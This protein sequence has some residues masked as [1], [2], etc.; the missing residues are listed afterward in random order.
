[1]G[2]TVP[3]RRTTQPKLPLLEQE[4]IWTAEA[5][6]GYFVS[7][8]FSAVETAIPAGILVVLLSGCGGPKEEGQPLVASEF[9]GLPSVVLIS[10]DTLRADHL[11]VYGYP[12]PTSPFL[13]S[14][15][16]ECVVFENVIAPCPST[17][18]SVASIMT[19]LNRAR[20]GLIKNQAILPEDVVT[21]AEYL[22]AQGYTTI[23]VNAHPLL[24]TGTPG[25]DQ[26][27]DVYFMPD[28]VPRDGPMRFDGS[29]L[30]D[31]VDRVL[32]KRGR[33][34]LFLW[35]HFVEPHG[36]YN[37]PAEYLA[38]FPPDSY[39]SPG[40]SELPVGE[41]NY[42]YGLIPEYQTIGPRKATVEEYIAAYDAEIRYVDDHVRR[43]AEVLER[44]R[45]WQES[46]VVVTADHGES[47]GEHD[48]YFQHGYHLYEGSVR[49]PLLMRAPRLFPPGARVHQ[50][51]S[52]LD[53]FPTVA[54]YVGIDPGIDFDGES[55]LSLCGGDGADRAVFSQTYYGNSLTALRRGELKYIWSPPPPAPESLDR[56]NSG[57]DAWWE[58][59]AS[60][61]FYDLA[62]DPEELANRVDQDAANSSLFRGLVQKWLALQKANARGRSPFFQDDEEL[63]RA[64]KA[65]GYTE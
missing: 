9:E 47:L 22:R 24:V 35:V 54:E 34:P 1:M 11:E 10:I 46:L 19:G 38:L 33:R 57:W 30:P 15:A 42:G 6:I 32:G 58:T 49:V 17:G 39:R 59:E 48:Y 45:L 65:L 8:R 50:T 51:V 61:E 23:G 20:H 60:E 13:E 28:E 52:L 26:G 25:F 7:M 41:T 55:L 21:L 64:M 14:L 53:L 37:P 36:P 43:V 31:A 16:E 62:R 63:D 27:F 2:L 29:S 12:R 4:R 18:P 3:V 56:W 40:A 44:H 5:R